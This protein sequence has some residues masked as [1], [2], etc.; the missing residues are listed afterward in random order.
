MDN[1]I[2]FIRLSLLHW[3]NGHFNHLMTY[4]L[5]LYRIPGVYSKEIHEIVQLLNFSR[6]R[7]NDNKTI[8]F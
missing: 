1:V 8:Q 2:N 4:L 6:Y 5:K 3:I 7:N